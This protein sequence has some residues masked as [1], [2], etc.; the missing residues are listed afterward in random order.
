[1]KKYY[2]YALLD[3]SKKGEYIYDDIKLEFEPFYI[4]KGTENR[5]KHSLKSK[6]NTF[7][8]SKIKSL[9]DRNIEIISI[10]LYEWLDNI[11]SLELEK[12]VIKKIGR[13][14][15]GLGPLTNL[16][17]GGDGRL[18]SPHSEETKY[19]LHLSS[20]KT[21]K[22]RKDLGTDKHTEETKQILRKANLGS[23]NPMFGKKHSDE[24][25]N[26]QSSR[27]SGINHPMFGK[28]HN[29]E[30]IE[31]IKLGRKLAINQEKINKITKER[32]SK[33]VNQYD[34]LG[35]FIKEFDSIKSAANET[36]ISESVIGKNCRGVIKNPTRFIF[37][38]K[39]VS[40]SILNN[41]FKYKI[42]DKFTIDQI[43]YTLIKRCK[44]TAIIKIYDILSHVKKS[45]YIFLWDKN[46][47]N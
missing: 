27:F 20:K 23:K 25:K 34:L 6:S 11:E 31:K 30:T 47:I 8:V 42:G 9:K 14:D 12:V 17:D 33:K 5:L 21:A 38:F 22:I 1:M 24:V 43:E 45:E 16:T 18:T 4:G 46:L 15:L 35:N 32:N 26:L 40:S 7:K 2:I 29:E 3:S 36:S 41:S 13:R 37:K 19:K 44:K 10:K 39:D 28:K